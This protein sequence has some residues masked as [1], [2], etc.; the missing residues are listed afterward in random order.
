MISAYNTGIIP[1]LGGLCGLRC[2]HRWSRTG[3]LSPG[4]PAHPARLERPRDRKSK[5]AAHL[6][7]GAEAKTTHKRTVDPWIVMG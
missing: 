4:L 5:N 7:P 3:W 2:N 6:N 1:Q